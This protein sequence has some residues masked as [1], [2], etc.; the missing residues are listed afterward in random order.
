[1][2]VSPWLEQVGATAVD[3]LPQARRVLKSYVWL[4]IAAAKLLFGVFLSPVVVLAC[5][6]ES[7]FAS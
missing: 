6:P 1:M 2:Q 3:A 7:A 4:R 5:S